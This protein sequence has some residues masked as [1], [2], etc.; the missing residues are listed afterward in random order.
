VTERVPIEI[1]PNPHNER[2][3]ETKSH[4]LGHYLNL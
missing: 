3:L 1:P 2:Y 4:K